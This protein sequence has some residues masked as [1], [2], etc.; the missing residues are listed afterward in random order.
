MRLTKFDKKFDK[1]VR[2]LQTRPPYFLTADRSP[3]KFLSLSNGKFLRRLCSRVGGRELQGTL[4]LSS[5]LKM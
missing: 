1:I 2:H 4:V 3:R 5:E